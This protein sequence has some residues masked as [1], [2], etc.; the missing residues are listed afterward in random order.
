MAW[1]VAFA[2]TPGIPDLWGWNPAAERQP[3]PSFVVL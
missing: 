3:Q 1:K 2:G